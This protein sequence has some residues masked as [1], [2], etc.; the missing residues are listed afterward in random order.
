MLCYKL[1][2][3][4]MHVA[5]CSFVYIIGCAIEELVSVQATMLTDVVRTPT[6]TDVAGGDGVGAGGKQ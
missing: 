3:D 2:H 5:L 4:V 1:Y 6:L